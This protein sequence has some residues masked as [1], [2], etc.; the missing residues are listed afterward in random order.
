ME[1]SSALTHHAMK[2]YMGLKV[3]LKMSTSGSDH[4]YSEV[5]DPQ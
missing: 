1:T 5:M 3:D 2:A 4:I